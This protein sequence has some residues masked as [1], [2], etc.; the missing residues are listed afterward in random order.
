LQD[1]I[2]RFV[3]GCPSRQSAFGRN[4]F[5][6]VKQL[7]KGKHTPLYQIRA[8]FRREDFQAIPPSPPG[9]QRAFRIMYIGRI[10]RYKGVFDI[11][12]M[13]KGIEAKATGRVRREICGT[14]PDL[15]AIR[16]LREQMSLQEV[17]TV[18]GW[19][20]SED[21]QKVYARS[22]AS[23]VPTRSDYMEGLAMTAAESDAV[24][25]ATEIQRGHGRTQRR[26]S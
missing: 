4:A 15:E 19:T 21:L 10:I 22:H 26:S 20:S 1:L 18:R 25:C 3:A 12:E 13:A 14:G 11:I 23:I 2:Q 5:G 24:R 16:R 6:Q 9:D 8:Q 17:I 7:T